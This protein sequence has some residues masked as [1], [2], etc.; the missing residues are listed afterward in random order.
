LVSLVPG[1][2]LAVGQ[3]E[4]LD[5]E[6]VE[7]VDLCVILRCDDGHVPFLSGRNSPDNLTHNA[8]S[9]A[10]P[11]AQL[12]SAF[13]VGTPKM[14]G[15]TLRVQPSKKVAAHRDEAGNRIDP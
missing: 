13:V 6:L 11:H 2:A 7:A 8:P 4:A 10:A 1:S 9:Q 3:A 5:L 15:E 12:H 14:R